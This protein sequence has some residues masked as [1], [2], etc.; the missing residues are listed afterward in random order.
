MQTVF[1]NLWR[2]A[3]FFFV[4]FM[5]LWCYRTLPDSIAFVHNE[6]GEPISWVDKQTFFYVSTAIIVV[7]NLLM[8]LAK[9]SISKLDFSKL[10]PQSEWARAKES[11][12]ELIEGWFNAFIAFVNT[13]LVFIFLGLNGINRTAE[14]LLDK[15]YNW[16]LIFLALVLMVL[17]FFIPLRLLFTQ[18]KQN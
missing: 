13:T 12:S 5:L 1:F 4:V 18:P 7:F 16:L 2:K 3:S 11:L 15:N 6:N 17:I 8:G 9:T 14:Q 10:N